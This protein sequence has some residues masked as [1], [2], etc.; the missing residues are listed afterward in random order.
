MALPGVA[1][2][3]PGE[4]MEMG[5]RRKGWQAAQTKGRSPE[6]PL[7]AGIPDFGAVCTVQNSVSGAGSAEM[8]KRTK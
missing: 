3:T 8:E 6:A 2:G 4:G 7:S 1:M 5:E